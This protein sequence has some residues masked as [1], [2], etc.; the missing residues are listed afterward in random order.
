[1]RSLPALLALMALGWM[2]GCATSGVAGQHTTVEHGGIPADHSQDGG[3]FGF[4]KQGDDFQI[5]QQSAGLEEDSWHK[6][7]EELETDDAQALWE[8]LARTRTTLQS[9]GPHRSLVFVLRQVLTRDEDVPYAQLLERLRP[10]HFLVVMRPDGYLVSALNG[11]SLQRMGMGRVELREGRLMAG[12]FEVGA[13][14]RDKGGVFYTVNDSLSQPG[15]MVGELGLERDWFNAALDGGG[16]ALGEM[17]QALARFVDDPIRSLQGLNQL[18]SAVA[19][20]IASSP[21]YF[22]RYSALPLQEQIREAARLSTHLV[23]LY[24]SAAGA[25][26]RIGTAGAKLPVLSLTAEGGLAIEQVALPVGATAAAVGTG[27]GAIYV[28]MESP[29]APDEGGQGQ[30]SGT[31]EG[32]EKLTPQQERAI[33]SLERQIRKHEEKLKDFRKDPTPRPGTE[34]LSAEIQQKS[35][36]GRIRHLE[37]EIETF[38]RN[39]EKI[40]Q[41]GGQE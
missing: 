27:A 40:R 4:W 9:F 25:V 33:Q 22:A 8:V 34:N 1:M 24:G 18:P 39:I 17:A 37:R 35:I 10:F 29:K 5:L 26:T 3:G 19:A 38:K 2:T 6:E 11:R 31:A 15:A 30:V 13:F 14:Y 36:E 28:L 21:D 20:L 16:D 12:A 23:M 41:G 7:G 32:G